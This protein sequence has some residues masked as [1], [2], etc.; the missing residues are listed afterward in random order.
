MLGWYFFVV[1]YLY[2]VVVRCCIFLPLTTGADVVAPV[3]VGLVSP[4]VGRVE[5]PHVRALL[6][7]LVPAL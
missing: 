5:R 4:K 1:F 6:C 2:F 3:A 7:F